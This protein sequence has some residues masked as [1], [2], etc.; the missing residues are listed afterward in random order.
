MEEQSK[1]FDLYGYITA[2][3]LQY[4]RE[5]LVKTPLAMAESLMKHSEFNMHCQ[6]HHYLV[7]AVLLTAA[8]RIQGRP[9][10]DLAKL[11]EKAQS[12]SQ[13]VLGKFCGLYG[14]C[15]A[16]IGIGIYASVLTDT[17]PYSVETWSLVNLGT[18]ES[19]LEMAKINGPRCCKRNTYLALQYASAFSREHLG[20]NLADCDTIQC[21][22]SSRNKECKR[23]QCPFY[24][25]SE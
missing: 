1:K 10:D 25:E 16:A 22:H 6:E 7:P 15:G 9:A 14:A 13:N 3:C 12:R 17:T 19:L 23:R 11:L 2:Q 21:R 5:S 24:C 18:A 20:V 8:C 4:F